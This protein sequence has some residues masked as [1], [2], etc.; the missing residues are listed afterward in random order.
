MTFLSI[1]TRCYKRP[2]ALRVNIMSV[3]RQTSRDWEQVFIVDDSE[4]GNGL[5]WANQSL[6]LNRYRVKGDYILILDDDDCLAYNRFVADL[7]NVVTEHEPDII[8]IKMDQILRILP[9][10]TVWKKHPLFGHIGSCCFVV[11]RDI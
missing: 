9:D 8:M 2:K 6:F 10:S 4:N 11:R 3:A 1:I 7:K 5:L